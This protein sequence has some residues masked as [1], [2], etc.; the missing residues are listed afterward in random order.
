MTPGD[1]FGYQVGDNGRLIL[2]GLTSEETLEFEILS[3]KGE[4]Q[5]DHAGDLRQQKLYLKQQ[6]AAAIGPKPSGRKASDPQRER[7]DHR[8]EI[9]ETLE[10]LSARSLNDFSD[11]PKGR[12]AVSRLAVSR[13][14]KRLGLRS[15]ATICGLFL[16]ASL[17]MIFLVQPLMNASICSLCSAHIVPARTGDECTPV[18]PPRRVACAI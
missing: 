3:R 18:G 5:L 6:T 17:L 2:P 15:M 9:Y 10:S 16:G 13:P 11:G 7:M 4:A 14:T 12:P 8:S 1:F